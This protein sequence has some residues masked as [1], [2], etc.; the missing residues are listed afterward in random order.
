MTFVFVN[1]LNHWYR[2]KANQETDPGPPGAKQPQPLSR[3]D[4]EEDTPPQRESP[5]QDR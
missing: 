2:R 4:G 3:E 5:D 1:L